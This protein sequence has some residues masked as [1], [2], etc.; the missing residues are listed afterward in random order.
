M[1]NN[2]TSNTI[3]EQPNLYDDIMWWK[4]DDIEFWRHIIKKTRAKKILELCCGTGRLS[5]PLINDGIDYYGIDSSISFTNHLKDKL[6]KNNYDS[7]KIICEDIKNFKINQSFDLIFIGF[8]SLAHLLQDKDALACFQSVINHMHDKSIF[9]IDIFVPSPLFLYRDSTEK[10]NIMDFVDSKNNEKLHILESTNYDF[11]TE[12]NHIHWDF[13][14]ND[15]INKFSYGFDMRMFFPDT[16]NKLLIDSNYSIQQFYGN[17][18]FSD[19]HEHSDKQI[20]L[21]TKHT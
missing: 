12:I 18:D 2:I 15:G 16:L 21:C 5:I 10:I 3:Y 14:N 17:Y 6:L 8:N 20:Y 7:N 9:G 4:K 13:L 1:N 11:N 19:F